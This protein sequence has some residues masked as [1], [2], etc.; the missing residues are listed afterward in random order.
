M[1]KRSSGVLLHPTS[2]PSRYGIGGLGRDA[3]RFIDFLNQAGFCLWQVLPL[4][5]PGYGHSPYMSPASLAY[6]TLMVCPDWLVARGWLNRP[7]APAV[8]ESTFVDFSRA[9]R[10][11]QACLQ[12]AYAGFIR[13]A[14][15]E[16]R[17][18]YERFKRKHRHLYDC[19][20]FACLSKERGCHWH[21]WPAHLRRLEP[22]TRARLLEHFDREVDHY[23]FGQFV[24]FRQWQD[25]RAYAW[26]KGVR[27]IVDIPLYVSFLSCDVWRHPDVFWLQPGSLLPRKVAGV[28]PDYFS[29]TGQ[30]W[31][32][33]L[34]RW[35]SNRKLRSEPLAWWLERFRHILALGDIVRIDHF[36]GLESF[37][38]VPY[39]SATATSGRWHKGPG[40]GLFRYLFQHLDRCDILA[41]DLGVITDKVRQLRV[42]MGF[43][44]M[45]VLQFAFS[46]PG[47]AFLPHNYTSDNYAVYTGTHD[48]NTTRGWYDDETTPESR[49]LIARYLGIGT[50]SSNVARRMVHFAMASPARWAIFPMQDLL[51]LGKRCRMNR[52]A[53]SGGNWRWKMRAADYERIDTDALREWQWLYNRQHG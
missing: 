3:L 52:P 36:R 12:A 8:K 20:L 47:N 16:D 37:W 39:G 19:A 33:P 28:P 45:K 48:N 17:D 13:R 46:D 5:P 27:I 18:V 14:T 53:Q 40:R 41:E 15:A 44:G 6:N 42:A 30:L 11:K 26:Q 1:R 32:N 9:A 38:A 51:N 23:L 50:N 34:Y 25:L 10:L 21:R 4:N 22:D 43:P 29:A 35:H 31:G 49:R 7:P 24:F 2:L